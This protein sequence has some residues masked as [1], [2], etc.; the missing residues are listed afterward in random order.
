MSRRRTCEEKKSGLIGRPTDRFARLG[1]KMLLA[2]AYRALTPNARALLVELAMMENGSNNGVK[3]YLSVRDA[4]DRM[5][6]A[7]LKAASAA[8]KELE[9]LGF[10]VMTADAHF[11]VKAGKGSR[12]R[13][14]RLTWQ[15]MNGRMGP[16][17][18]YEKREPEPKTAAHRRMRRG[19]QA[20]ARWRKDGQA[21]RERENRGEKIAM[22]NF[23]THSL[24]RVEDSSTLSSLL[25]IRTSGGVEHSATQFSDDGGKPPN[26]IVEDSTTYKATPASPSSVG[27]KTV[28]P[29]GLPCQLES[30]AGV[31]ETGP[32]PRG[33]ASRQPPGCAPAAPQSPS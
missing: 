21:N 4:A 19:L 20:L 22:V 16:T 30:P 7:D 8:F 32:L 9:A 27:S 15:A 33:A 14:W 2:S 10:I 23:A 13:V 26:L 28:A 29:D 3:L 5:G 12:A 18:D 6:V 1:H 25:L 31:D 11:A 17:V 24:N